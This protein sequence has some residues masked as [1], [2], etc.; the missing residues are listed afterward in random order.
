MKKKVLLY[1]LF[2]FQILCLIFLFTVGLLYYR[3]TSYRK[4]IVLAPFKFHIFW[5]DLFKYCIFEIYNTID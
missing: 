2:S 4:Y 3:Q 5:Y 1:L